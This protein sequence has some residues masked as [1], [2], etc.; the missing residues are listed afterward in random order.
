MAS[1]IKVIINAKGVITGGKEVEQGLERVRAK[2]K[3][4]QADL[5][6]AVKVDVKASIPQLNQFGDSLS[7][8]SGGLGLIGKAGIAGTILFGFAKAAISAADE[9][10]RLQNAL[11]GL[12]TVARNTG[13][14]VGV[15]TKAAKDLSAD[16]L[17]PLEDTAAALKNLLATGL[18][19]DQS[20]KLFN[21]LKDS[22]AFNRQGFLSM[23]EAIKGATEG[24][25]NGNSILV[26]N[27]GITKNLSIFQKE[28]AASIGTTV[29]KLTDAQKI[30]A[31]YVGIL[32][33]A[34]KFTGDAAKLTDTYTGAKARLSTAIDRATAALGDFITQSG[35]VKGAMAALSDILERAV[36]KDAA[37]RIKDINLELKT[38]SRFSLSDEFRK[39]G[40]IEELVLLQKE[41]EIEKL[42]SAQG[43]FDAKV[44]R[45]QIDLAKQKEEAER[46]AAE[47][48]ASRLKEV[49]KLKKQLIDA[50]KSE[51]DALKDLRDR[52]LAMAKGD[53]DARLLIEK[54]YQAN[55]KKLEEKG[56]KSSTKLAKDSLKE[57]VQL[58]KVSREI[59]TE[60]AAN[61]FARSGNLRDLKT[62]REQLIQMK[63]DGE[64]E[65]LFKKIKGLDKKISVGEKAESLGLGL[66]LAGNVVQG[67][68]G[69]QGLVSA[70]A[71]LGLDAIMPGLGQA[72]KPLLD[73]FTQGP[74]ATRAMVKEFAKALPDIVQGFI[75]AVPAFVEE[76]A[77]QSPVIIERLAEK[78]PSIIEHLIKAL[79]KVTAAVILMMPKLAYKFITELIKNVPRIVSE[80][81]RAVYEGIKNVLK[82]LT[83]TGAGGV[84]GG[85]AG[86]G[87]VQ[88]A[89]TTGPTNNGTVNLGL[90]VLT[91]GASGGAT[92]VYKSLKKRLGFAQGGE[93]VRLARGGTPWQDSIPTMVQQGEVTIDRSTT[94]KLKKKLDGDGFG[95][96]ISA[97][98]NQLIDLLSKPMEVTSDVKFNNETMAKIILNLTRTNQRLA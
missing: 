29:G 4:T 24:I 8:I 41:V 34:E 91:F 46:K 82:K 55:K 16:G 33:E 74:A 21:S 1:E 76:L 44:K 26:D 18:S 73:A 63:G 28:Y 83:G 27:A 66:G 88:G 67:K 6:R 89:L 72:A 13:N 43:E 57:I 52:R 7:R 25:K 69:A 37:G 71:A 3:Q 95:V 42:R 60:T 87:G 50:G 45:E 65:E 53:A 10:E 92:T 51:L 64:S 68:S 70:G 56:A 77:N 48:E 35:L 96:D 11:L 58:N 47:A 39:K 98:L 2:A 84:F 22:A 5:E 93:A 31:A 9:S 81:A 85:K 97:Q 30:T 14:D 38:L 61:P 17:V 19:A 12:K 36:G 79:P 94:T 86:G 62:A 59:L 78:A 49:G 75:E 20:I 32:K 40:L 23:G 54:D 80:I 15:I 90:N